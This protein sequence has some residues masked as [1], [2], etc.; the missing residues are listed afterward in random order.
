M[1]NKIIEKPASKPIE[2][3]KIC[4]INKPSIIIFP[5]TLVSTHYLTPY[6]ADLTQPFSDKDLP[7]I[8]FLLADVETQA[9]SSIDLEEGEDDC[10]GDGWQQFTENG[11]TDEASCRAYFES[12]Y[13]NRITGFVDD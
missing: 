8:P 6:A 7:E 2:P 5:S 10:T 9:T 11:I 12:L 3:D 13:N 1:L 4:T